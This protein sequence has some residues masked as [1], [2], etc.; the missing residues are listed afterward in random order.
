MESTLIP[1]SRPFAER[2]RRPFMEKLITEYVDI[3]AVTH[4]VEHIVVPIDD[5]NRER[6]IETLYDILTKPKKIPA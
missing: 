5:E 1:T 2:F 4:P 6:I 3:A